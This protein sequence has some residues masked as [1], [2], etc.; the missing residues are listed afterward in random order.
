MK[1]CSSPLQNDQTR[2]LSERILGKINQLNQGLS[3]QGLQ[4]QGSAETQIKDRLSCT[5]E[6]IK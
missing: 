5:N 3:T 2:Y 6:A 4:S 1:V